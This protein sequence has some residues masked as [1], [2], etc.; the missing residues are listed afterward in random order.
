MGRISKVIFAWA[1]M[2]SAT[3][4]FITW[5]WSSGE[6]GKTQEEASRISMLEEE[7]INSENLD[8]AIREMASK[9]RSD[10]ESST[11]GDGS[12]W[13]A[14]EYLEA[15]DKKQHFLAAMYALYGA[16]QGVSEAQAYSGRI[17]LEGNGVGIDYMEAAYWFKKSSDQNN[18]LGQH[19]LGYLYLNGLGVAKDLNN[20]NELFRKSC[21][22]ADSKSDPSCKS[23]EK[24]LR[25]LRHL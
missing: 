2:L 24:L 6:N 19:L 16:A 4:L 3:F 15:Y 22:A 11:G 12:Y 7:Y 10:L 20:A 9:A 17:F 1:T 18:R 21:E 8:S 5:P 25:I 23:Y 14:S 13:A